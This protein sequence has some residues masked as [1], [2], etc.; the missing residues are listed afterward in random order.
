MFPPHPHIPHQHQQSPSPSTPLHQH[1][2]HPRPQSPN[3]DDT[4]AK[5]QRTDN[6]LCD[7]QQHNAHDCP[8][9][10]KTQQGTPRSGSTTS[11]R[12]IPHTD[13]QSPSTSSPSHP[14]NDIGIDDN[15]G[16]G[17]TYTF[18][19]HKSAIDFLPSPTK[20]APTFAAFDHGDHYH[21]IYGVKHTNNASRQLTT[22]LGFLKAGLAGN[23]EAHTTLQLVRFANRF[24]SYLIRKGLATFSKFGSR[25]LS[26]IKPITKAFL[27]HQPSEDTTDS[28][29]PCHQYI[30]DKKTTEHQTVNTRTFSIDYISSLIQDNSITSYEE[31]QRK[32]PTSIK[33]QLLKQL[34]Y[35]GQ[36]IIKTLI[37]IYNTENL[38]TFRSQHYYSLLHNNYIPSQTAPA[39]VSWLSSLFRKNRISIPDFFAHFLAIHSMALTKINSFILQGPTDT[40]KSLLLHLLL[41]DTYPT[42]IA[43]ERDKSNFHLDQLPNATSVVFEEPIIDQTTIGTWK[44]LLEGAPLPTDM[45]HTDKEPSIASPSSSPPTIPFGIGLAPTTY[46]PYNSVHSLT[47]S[48]PPYPATSPKH[49]PWPLHHHQTRPVRPLLT[50]PPRHSYLIHR[51]PCHVS[52]LSHNQTSHTP[53]IPKPTTTPNFPPLAGQQRHPWLIPRRRI[54]PGKNLASPPTSSSDKHPTTSSKMAMA[55]TSTPQHPPYPS[56]SKHLLYMDK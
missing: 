32:L 50:L 16:S 6:G 48:L 13:E 7:T 44:L 37:K 3:I 43:R 21:F 26:I 28:S 33:I 40:G 55:S 10:N 1:S 36:N 56:P 24:L 42:R 30:E 25:T 4:R 20:R 45:K 17:S 27:N 54:N 2:P 38:Q 41:E 35:V 52:P 39:N 5:R 14:R 9:G 22:I 19:I 8:T 29:L 15:D 11:P 51:P 49:N 18:I 46:L 53:T 34:G 31:F 23:T 47:T 12:H